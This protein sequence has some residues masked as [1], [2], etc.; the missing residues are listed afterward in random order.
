M[1]VINLRGDTVVV[2]TV[3]NEQR[4]QLINLLAGTQMPSLRKQ[5]T[6][7][8]YSLSD[9]RVLVEFFDRQGIILQSAAD[10][11]R[12]RGVKFFKTYVDFLKRNI[13]Y[14]I[15][16]SLEDGKAL[17][18]HSGVRLTQFVPE[19]PEIFPYEVYRLPTGQ[20]LKLIL[21]SVRRKAIIYAD[22]KGMCS[23]DA[24]ILGQVYGGL[25]EATTRFINGDAQLDYNPPEFLIWPSDE[26]K[27]IASHDLQ[28]LE[29]HVYVS[30][31]YG[32]LYRSPEGYYVLLDDFSQKDAGGHNPIGIGTARI[33]R[34]LEEVRTAKAHYQRRKKEPI[35][36]EHFYQHISERYGQRFP[37]L[38]PSL[39][40]TMAKTLNIDRADLTLDS[41]G[42]NVL[43]EAIY[44]NHDSSS[45]FN[46]W[47]PGV[48]G[49]YGTC[50]IRARNEGVWAVEKEGELDVWVPH[51]VLQ[52]GDAAFDSNQFY[53]T[54]SEW[55]VPLQDAG[56]W[57]GHMRRWKRN[58]KK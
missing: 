8:T 3:S 22:L 41:A 39:I 16:L 9:G 36:D 40:D 33:Y 28:L 13:T 14:K 31:F 45:L 38:V 52:D 51:V 50:Y 25:E 2:E 19:M 57:E 29:K 54:L 43:D 12:L 7:R 30:D 18:Q 10:L 47:Y 35:R 23:E 49:F 27:A 15:E 48:L 20:L 42:L 24:E 4:Q 21:Q 26:S 6:A 53:K 37:M 56:D 11:E 44:W 17:A 55:P 5:Y 34:T 32:N 58:Q 46:A 1:Q